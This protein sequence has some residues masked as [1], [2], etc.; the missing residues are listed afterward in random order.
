MEEKAISLH[1]AGRRVC[2]IAKELGCSESTIYKTFRLAGYKLPKYNPNRSGGRLWTDEEIQYLHDNPAKPPAEMAKELNRTYSAVTTKIA[3]L[4]AH[5][6]HNC[7]V[8]NVEISQKGKFCT[9]HNWVGRRAAQAAYRAKG[10]GREYTLTEEQVVLLV[11]QPCTYCGQ[12][13]GGLGRVDSSVGYTPENTV[14][15]CRLCNV[16]KNNLS[17]DEWLAHLKKIME[18]YNA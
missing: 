5:R 6:R 16:M 15:C 10:K 13:G 18:Y 14:P 3:K 2:E 9:P 8:C 7:L 12:D 11:Q 1:R 17:V 4:D